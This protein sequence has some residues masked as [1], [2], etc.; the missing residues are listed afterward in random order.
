[1]SDF[2]QWN[3][4]ASGNNSGGDGSKNDFLKLESGNS[5][6]IRPLFYPIQFWKYFH[7]HNEKL[8]TA[9][10][11][12]PDT[13][14]VRASHPELGKAALRFAAYVIDRA[15][16]KIKILEA[17]QSVFRPIGNRAEATNKNPG[18][19][20]EGSDWII[21]VSGQGMKK[22]YEVTYLDQTPLSSAEKSLVK[23]ALNGDKNKLKS[24]YPSDSP[25]K[26]EKKL[27]GDFSNNEE[28]SSGISSE[29]DGSSVSSEDDFTW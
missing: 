6:K 2:V 20:T 16:G 23:E 3:D 25:E 4:V 22:R 19:I 26:I 14:P 28:D 24:I 17:P 9:I 27:F 12:D 29:V 7:K 21:K 13:C 11:E 1:M 10:C 15:D 5:Y 18:D 8:R